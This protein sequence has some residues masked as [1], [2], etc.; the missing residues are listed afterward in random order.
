MQFSTWST[1]PEPCHPSRCN[2]LQE[3]LLPAARLQVGPGDSQEPPWEI[4]TAEGK[5][6]GAG[7]GLVEQGGWHRCGPKR[8]FSSLQSMP[9]FTERETDV[10]RGGALC[11]STQRPA[12]RLWEV[13]AVNPVSGCVR[14]DSSSGAGAHLAAAQFPFWLHPG[15]GRLR[16]V[17]PEL[18]QRQGDRDPQQRRRRAPCPPPREARCLLYLTRAGLAGAPRGVGSGSP[19]SW[20][21]R[22]RVPGRTKPGPGLPRRRRRSWGWARPPRAGEDA[23]CGMQPPRPIA[24]REEGLVPWQQPMAAP[25]RGPAAAAGRRASG[26]VQGLRV[27]RGV[28]PL[29]GK[30]APRGLGLRVPHTFRIKRP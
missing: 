4:S 30:G 8:P 10:Q 16:R 28:N 13:R 25:G 14:G 11:P 24:A 17:C 21:R 29:Q 1:L 6:P 27:Q 7:A 15:E 12:C 23:G 20:R 9:H 22:Q 3:A 18:K 26:R 5:A 19:G 2:F